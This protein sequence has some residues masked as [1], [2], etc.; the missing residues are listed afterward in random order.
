MFNC[1]VCGVTQP[2]CAQPTRVV[3]E[4]RARGN[5]GRSGWE[6]AREAVCCAACAAQ[7]PDVVAEAKVRAATERTAAETAKRLAA[8]AAHVDGEVGGG[9]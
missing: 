6:I 8:R 3:V 4:V 5:N 7:L 9:S 2:P 1:Q